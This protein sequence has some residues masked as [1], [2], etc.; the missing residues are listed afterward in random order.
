MVAYP[1]NLCVQYFVDAHI[2]IEDLYPES[3]SLLFQWRGLR[4]VQNLSLQD[5][6]HY[7]VQMTIAGE[8]TSLWVI[9]GRRIASIIGDFAASFF[10]Q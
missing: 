1:L 8:I 6:N 5:G 7:I 4:R 10:N 3:Y 9:L 2:I